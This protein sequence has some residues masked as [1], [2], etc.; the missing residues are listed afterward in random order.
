LLFIEW[1]KISISSCKSWRR[2]STF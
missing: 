2:Y 1:C